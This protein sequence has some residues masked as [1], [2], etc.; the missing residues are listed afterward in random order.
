MYSLKLNTFIYTN[1]PLR[2]FSIYFCIVLKANICDDFDPVNES[3]TARTVK[4]FSYKLF[5][6]TICIPGK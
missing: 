5:P 6:F 2:E 4:R 3:L 1:Q